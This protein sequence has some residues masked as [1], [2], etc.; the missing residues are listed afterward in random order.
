MAKSK[1]DKKADA[2]KQRVVVRN[3]KASHNYD[4]ID[5]LDC[6]IVLLGSEVKSIRNGKITI[7]EAYGRLQN[8]ELWLIN[9]DIAEYPQASFMNHERKRERKLLVRK[10]QLRKF[11]ETAD[12]QG[13]TM[14]PLSVYFERGIVKVKLAVGRGRKKHD[15]RDKLKTKDDAREM[16]AAKQVRLA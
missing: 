15:K 5:E 12:H 1:S 10:A 8:G 2:S 3:R 11:A 9:S 7:D 13:L 6:G 14:V 4:L 16:R